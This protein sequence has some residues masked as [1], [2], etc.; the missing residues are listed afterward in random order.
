VTVPN[1]LI[2]L[3]DLR[4]ESIDVTLYRDGKP[5]MT[6]RSVPYGGQAEFGLETTLWCTL[7]YD[8]VEG[9]TV[10]RDV[11][12]LQFTPIDLTG[13][14]SLTFGL[15]G[16]RERGYI[17]KTISKTIQ[18]PDYFRRAATPVVLPRPLAR[19]LYGGFR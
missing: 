3:N 2:V 10:T 9:E 4:T 8:T 15:Y 19:S 5:V 16:S 11:T 13:L 6:Q 18:A 17:L 14:S 1:E 7:A 12:N